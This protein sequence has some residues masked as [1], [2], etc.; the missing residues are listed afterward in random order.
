MLITFTSEASANITMFGDIAISLIKA[1]GQSGK[2][3]GAITATNVPLALEKLEKSL[4]RYP[5][6]INQ[7]DSE[8][9]SVSIHLR[10]V[11]LIKMLKASIDREADIMWD[12][13]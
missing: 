1:M 5:D 11:P 3:P 12:R 13:E 4:A 2:V 7:D 9:E 8:D 10:A 6:E